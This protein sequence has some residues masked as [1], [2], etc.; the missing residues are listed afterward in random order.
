MVLKRTAND[1]L[2]VEFDDGFDG[3][4]RVY[5]NTKEFTSKDLVVKAM[6]REESQAATA[7]TV[8]ADN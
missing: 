7:P 2:Y 6:K 5:L 3:L 4:N 8:G 1:A